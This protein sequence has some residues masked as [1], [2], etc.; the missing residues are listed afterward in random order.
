MA[1]IGMVVAALVAGLFGGAIMQFLMPAPQPVGPSDADIRAV[2]QTVLA[3][4]P[5]V[6]GPPQ[7]SVATVDPE[8]LNP[9][10]E[11]YLMSDPKILQRV[12]DALQDVLQR[13]D[14]E[15][16]RVSLASFQDELYNDPDHVVLGNPDGDVTLIEFFDYN[17]GYCR[18]SMPDI[19]RLLQEDPE[20]RIILK[21]FP[22]LSEDSMDAARVAV[23]V[24]Q[25]QDVDYWDFHETLFTSRGQVNGQTALDAAQDLGLNPVNLQLA[26]SDA[27]ITDILQRSYIMAQGLNI[28]G[29][30]TFIIG[31]EILPG[32][33]G[34]DAL[35]TRIANMRECGSTLCGG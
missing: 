32:A 9:M 2:V 15:R 18:S 4:Q 17:C 8:T 22:I 6:Q 10:I 5:A 25:S 34:Y 16:A 28:S 27:E 7:M 14:I 33:V 29:T 23:A 24:S 11:D 13:E 3:E 21:E 30:P 31:D 26:A 1:R 20:L 12:S 19:A 35:K